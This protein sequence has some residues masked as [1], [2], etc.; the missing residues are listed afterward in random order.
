MMCVCYFEKALCPPVAVCL[1]YK[2]Q[3]QV[4][5]WVVSPADALW[6]DRDHNFLIWTMI[7]I[8]QKPTFWSLRKGVQIQCISAPSKPQ[9]N[10]LQLHVTSKQLKLLTFNTILTMKLDR[11]YK[12]KLFQVAEYI[13]IKFYTKTVCTI[14]K[15]LQ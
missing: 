15:I 10:E 8:L 1:L 9:N 6:E 12:E 14:E 11:F 2:L 7:Q 5:H 13:L 3:H 4:V